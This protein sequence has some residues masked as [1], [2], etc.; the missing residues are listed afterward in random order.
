MVNDLLTPT[1]RRSSSPAKAGDPVN[2]AVR[3][4]SEP[5]VFTGCPAFAGHDESELKTGRTRHCGGAGTAGPPLQLAAD[6]AAGADRIL[7]PRAVAQHEAAAHQRGHDPPLEAAGL[8]DG[9]AGAG[10]A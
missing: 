3:D 7:D 8:V 6:V 4:L 9:V 1:T 10:A 5:V 2:D